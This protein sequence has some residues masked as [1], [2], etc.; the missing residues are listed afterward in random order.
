MNNI[1]I[2]IHSVLPV[3]VAI[4]AVHLQIFVTG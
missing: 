3:C 1:A 2:A 4:S